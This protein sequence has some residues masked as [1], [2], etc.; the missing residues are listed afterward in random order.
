MRYLGY[1]DKIFIHP[2]VFLPYFC[3]ILLRYRAAAQNATSAL[4]AGWTA[5]VDPTSGRTYY[6]NATTG[7]T[8]WEVPTE[9]PAVAATVAPV[10][11]NVAPVVVSIGSEYCYSLINIHVFS[12]SCTRNINLPLKICIIKEVVVIIFSGENDNEGKRYGFF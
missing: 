2:L 6:V 3:C 7:Q 9:T 11:T 10:A 1:L 12:R 4:P 5:A 8:S